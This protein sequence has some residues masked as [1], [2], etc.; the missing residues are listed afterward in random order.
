MAK[1]HSFSGFSARLA[2]IGAIALTLILG[3]AFALTADP[4]EAQKKK[5]DVPTSTPKSAWVK[6]CEKGVVPVKDKDGKE[7]KKQINVCETVAERIDANSGMTLIAAGMK[8]VKIDSEEKQSFMVTL[9]HGVLLPAG[10]T[11]TFVPK[12]LWTK[13]EKNEKIEKDDQAKLKQVKLP[14]IFCSAVGCHIEAEFKDDGIKTLKSSAGIVIS[15]GT[16]TGLGISHKVSLAGFN[17]T[18]AG[19]AT[20]TK[21]FAELRKKLME[22]IAERRKQMI[23]EFKKKQEELNKMQPNV[24]PPPAK[25]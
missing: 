15:I 5:A 21:K 24:T 17:E 6:L 23:A 16:I 13:I 9:P 10:A 3:L 12:E 4:A 7:L 8:Q 18:V 19:P 25:K 14:F 2:S 11:V 20:D 1:S 22:D